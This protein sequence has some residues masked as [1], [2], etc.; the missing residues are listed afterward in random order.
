MVRNEKVLPF[1][2]W[3]AARSLLLLIAFCMS[4]ST[5]RAKPAKVLDMME[6]F[7]KNSHR[8]FAVKGEFV[9]NVGELQLNITNWGLI[10]AHP[11]AQTGYSDAPSAMWPAGSGVDYL[12]A[13]GVWIGAIKNGV[14]LVST[15]Q[16]IPELSANP[17][18]PLDTVYA[19]TQ[20]A[21]G[22]ARYPDPAE[23]DDGDGA[24]DEDPL[25]AIDDDA[26]GLID[27]DFA[28][29]GNQHFR[30]VMR[31]NTALA[32]E[33]FPDHDP[34]DIQVVQE[35]FAWESDAVDDFIGF[36]F[37]IK[38]IGP[39]P[40][41]D[42]YLGFFADGDA[43]PRG[44]SDVANDDLVHFV[45]RSVRAQDNSLVPL[46]IG[47]IYDADGDG[48]QTTG[49]FGML[50]LNH[51]TDPSGESAP[52][53]VGITTFQAF[54]V[55][56]PFDLGGD[57][58]NDAERYELLSRAEID[59]TPPLFQEG[60]QN[61][62]RIVMGSGPFVRL[63]P[64]ETLEYQ[65]AFVVGEGEAGMLRNAAEAA[66]T[67]YGSYFD[68]DVNPTT[69][70]NGWEKR[71][72]QEDFG[73]PSPTNPIFGIFQDCIDSVDL[74]GE[75]PPPP[76]ASDDLDE[77]GCIYIDSDC[78]F[79]ESRG[80][81]NCNREWAGLASE[82]L[83]GCT[84]VEGKEFQVTWL[85]GLPPPAPHMR[86]WQA[87]GRIHV[88][89]DN[90]SQIVPDVRLQEIDFESYKVWRADGWDR[91]FGASIENGPESGLWKLL[92]E[93]DKVDFFEDRRETRN[94]T[95]LQ[96][97]PLG[98]NT[99]LDV[100]RYQPKQLRLR[101][102][103]ALRYADGAQLI[104]DILATE[105]FSFLGATIDPADFVRYFGRSGEIT[106]IGLRFPQLQEWEGK[107]AVLDT[108]YWDQNG[109]KFYEY[110]DR[111]VH[112]GIH[113]F[114]SVTA[115]DFAAEASPDGARA[116]GQ[117]LT[118]D[119]QSNFSFA[120]PT[121]D[122]QT[123]EER[124]RLGQDI[125]VVPNPATRAALAEFSQLNPNGDDP[126]GVRVMFSNLPRARNTIKIFTL[127]GDLV[128][129]LHHDGISGSGSVS[130]NLVSRNGQEVVSGIYL[131]SV[132]AS[133]PA[134]DR[135]IG[136]FVVVR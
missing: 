89:F 40:L 121:S 65:A 29:I 136:R 124:K 62:W 17:D 104:A 8:E 23:D 60:R 48:G 52:P 5:A 127:S 47:S 77:N 33:R 44:A 111:S 35:S 64:G 100:I 134:F 98:A 46:S 97:L 42:V 119:P 120:I 31:D 87:N 78:D 63:D 45:R 32:E 38:N 81:E 70:A 112:N 83:A 1:R 61:D 125:Y 114:Y 85:V 110:V 9:H 53:R 10:G 96:I 102:D 54:S 6:L 72:C 68:R 30:L 50:F 74:I 15:G 66:L 129:T 43:G 57:P 12:W 93:F 103:E 106:S 95:V 59:N 115:S 27:E 21:P 7:G 41:K 2:I 11:G 105:E 26:D 88:F 91:P 24:I 14:P 126:T 19:T 20:G 84:G 28:A 122:A 56:R 67:Y 16:P 4:G 135:V 118:G 79:E 3:P 86:L 75:N 108:F 94:G 131:Y 101:S 130:W 22:G 36:Q 82:D 128:Q 49:F 34:L 69:G 107:Y 92:A 71:I 58:G 51:P 18:D 117:G 123:A 13:A 25:N 76:I 116:I 132:E 109:V 133:D 55:R 113:Y 39:S 37:E 90:I 80:N 99:G 73:P